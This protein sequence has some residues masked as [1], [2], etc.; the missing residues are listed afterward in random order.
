MRHTSIK[1]NTPCE[2][3]NV[4]I[5]DERAITK[6]FRLF[7]LIQGSDDFKLGPEAVIAMLHVPFLI[8]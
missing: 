5:E 8:E 4:T 7:C 3:I 6:K 1:L 2:F